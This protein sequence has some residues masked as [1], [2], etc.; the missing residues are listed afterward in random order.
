[1]NRDRREALRRLGRLLENSGDR[2]V[3]A[4]RLADL[5][6]NTGSYRWV[7]IYEISGN[8]IALIA[9]SGAGSPAFPR[10]PISQ[11]L[12][13]AAVS[14]GT[15]VVVGNV[16][17][18]PRSLTTFG[19]TR[20]EIVIP[21]KHPAAGKVFGVIDVESERLNAFTDD[22]RRFLEECARLIAARWK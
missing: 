17:K 13:G 21:L 22:D 5:I 16:T 4:G 1:M 9:W 20:S 7:G 12:C 18:D 15:T 19:S 11:G 14:S 10:F 2:T 3:N 8:E 6:R